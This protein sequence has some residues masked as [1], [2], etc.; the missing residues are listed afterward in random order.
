MIPTRES[1]GLSLIFCSFG[2]YF[3]SFEGCT[4]ILFCIAEYWGTQNMYSSEHVFCDL[5]I[6]IYARGCTLFGDM[7]HLYARGCAL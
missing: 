6:Y 4:D 5:Y 2:L 7:F 3:M 1:R